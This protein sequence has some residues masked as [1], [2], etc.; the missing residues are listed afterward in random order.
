MSIPLWT[1]S[2]L[3]SLIHLQSFLGILMENFC[4]NRTILTCPS[5]LLWR[6]LETILVKLPMLKVDFRTPPF[7]RSA[8]GVSS[9]V[10]GQAHPDLLKDLL[11]VILSGYLF[12][13]WILVFASCHLGTS[14]SELCM[15]LVLDVPAFSFWVFL[16]WYS[17]L[18][19]Y[20]DYLNRLF[21]IYFDSFSYSLSVIFVD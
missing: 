8:F 13:V 6:T 17:I 2:A 14:V 20:H 5:V 18:E 15:D 19:F 1:S 12:G 16:T 9:L 4:N 21:L 7:W 11:W 10:D 3:P